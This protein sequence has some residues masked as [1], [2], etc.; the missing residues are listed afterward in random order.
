VTHDIILCTIRRAIRK[1]RRLGPVTRALFGV[2]HALLLLFTVSACRPV[3]SYFDRDGSLSKVDG[4]GQAKSRKA[5][6]ITDAGN[7]RRWHAGS[8]HSG[9]VDDQATISGTRARGARRTPQAQQGVTWAGSTLNVAHREALGSPSKLRR[10]WPR[11]PF[12][13]VEQS[14]T[15]HAECHAS[16]PSQSKS[17]PHPERPTAQKQQKKKK[18]KK[19]KTKNKNSKRGG[20]RQK[21]EEK[22]KKKKKRGKKK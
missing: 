5:G 10:R 20:W 4:E 13:S 7:T 19:N 16:A 22:K 1:S 15:S 8:R 21:K 11:V 9:P 6:G 18:K 3:E 17:S 2:R 14:Q 12:V